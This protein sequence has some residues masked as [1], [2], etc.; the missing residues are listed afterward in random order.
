MAIKV[1]DELSGKTFETLQVLWSSALARDA[2]Q[3][4]G[5][6]VNYGWR[7]RTADQ[8]KAWAKE[9]DALSDTWVPVEVLP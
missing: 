1:R 2:T 5:A 8:H 3:T 4:R 6:L 9:D 7:S